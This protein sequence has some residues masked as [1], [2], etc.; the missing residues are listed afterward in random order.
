MVRLVLR[1]WRDCHEDWKSIKQQLKEDEED[2]LREEEEERAL[3]GND[4]ASDSS[5]P[6]PSKP[7]SPKPASPS[8]DKPAITIE[9][10][11]D[12]TANSLQAMKL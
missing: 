4:P 1:S 3:D 9:I 12:E 6:P 7:A 10:Q 11:S 5:T 8:S 2:R